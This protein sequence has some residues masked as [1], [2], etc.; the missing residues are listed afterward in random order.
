MLG[1]VQYVTTITLEYVHVTTLTLGYVHVTTITLGY[2]HVTTI[3]LGYVQYVTTITL[4]YVH[5]TT[6]TLGYYFLLIFVPYET[7]SHFVLL[8]VSTPDILFLHVPV[9]YSDANCVNQTSCYEA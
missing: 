1:Y 3:T 5:L 2:V 4:G 7:F 9:S 6:I 8:L